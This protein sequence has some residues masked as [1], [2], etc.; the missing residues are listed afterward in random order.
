M[1]IVIAGGSG[2][3]GRALSDALRTAGHELTVLSRRRPPTGVVTSPAV[4]PWTPDGSAG[5]WASVIEGADLVVNLAGESIAAGRWSPARKKAILESRV[6]AT[7][8]LVAA[9]D[10]T[11]RPPLALVSASAQGYYGDRGD[12]EVTE[13]APAGSDF[14]ANVCA[15]WEA[16]AARAERSSRV[17]LL[18][19]GIVL[20]GREGALPRMVLP[21]RAFAGGPVGSGRQYMAWIHWRDWV[22]LVV[23]AIGNEKLAG[24]INLSAPQPLR[25]ADFAASIGRAL[26]RPSWLPAPAFALKAALGE[27]AEAL[28]LTSIR[29]LPARALQL[30][31]RFRFETVDEA[32][33]DLL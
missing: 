17:V 33:R 21:F 29:M 2:F 1:K 4:V 14:L 18:R 8:S 3:L 25:N 16:E 24:A 6:L 30:G 13:S 23:W 5:G 9:M 31:F 15:R 32:L 28:L 26:N 27:M 12:A 20:S 11:T 19:T 22:D 7:R 10:A